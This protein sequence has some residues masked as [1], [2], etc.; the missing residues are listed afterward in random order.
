M[1]IDIH[2]L[3]SS[4]FQYKAEKLSIKMINRSG[5]AVAEDDADSSGDNHESE[6]CANC[7]WLHHNTTAWIPTLNTTKVWTVTN[8][9]EKN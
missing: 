2:H 3:L 6:T 5:F 4:S 7:I 9:G 1:L 8:F